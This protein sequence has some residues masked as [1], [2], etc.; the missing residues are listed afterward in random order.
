MEAYEQ[1]EF[2][3]PCMECHQ[4]ILW[5]DVYYK[6][7]DYVFCKDCLEKV[8]EELFHVVRH[9]LGSEEP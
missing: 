7:G 3:V 9:V 1:V 6:V 4:E 5:G 2:F 8:V